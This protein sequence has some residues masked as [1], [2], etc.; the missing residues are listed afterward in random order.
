MLGV[1][2]VTD[3]QN[4]AF[5]CTVAAESNLSTAAVTILGVTQLTPLSLLQVQY[6]V[7]VLVE[8]HPV[9]AAY[10]STPSSAYSQLVS[11]LNSSVHSGAF[12]SLLH[13][14]SAASDGGV[15]GPPVYSDYISFDPFMTP[16][17]APSG[18]AQSVSVAGVSTSNVFASN[19]FMYA[20]AAVCALIGACCLFVVALYMRR[21]FNA[22][23]ADKL[24]VISRRFSRGMD[25]AAEIGAF[26]DMEISPNHGDLVESAHS[27][28]V[29][30]R[31]SSIISHP[32]RSQHYLFM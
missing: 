27:V 7:T 2:I 1:A 23:T 24:R 28:D 8:V 19:G 10:A 29:P 16:S 5:V 30:R 25:G 3:L 12:T 4:S 14:V 31:P 9:A 11:R 6:A 20:I 21:R 17:A 26:D 32:H 15:F 22:P 18:A 13:A